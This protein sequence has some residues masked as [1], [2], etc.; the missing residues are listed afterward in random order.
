MKL[1]RNDFILIIIILAAALLSFAAYRLLYH[2]QGDSVQVTVDSRVIKT[3]P[4]DT[5]ATYTIHSKDSGSNVLVIKNGAAS[6]REANCSDE[7][8]VHHKEI[9]AQGESII[10]LPHKVVVSVISS[11]KATLDGV[12]Q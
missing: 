4:L 7:V 2:K 3:L 1:K 10:C 9:S 6:I 11:K 5:D 12:A 8:C